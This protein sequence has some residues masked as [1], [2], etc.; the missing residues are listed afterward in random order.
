MTI[1]R[2][3]KRRIRREIGEFP[4]ALQRGVEERSGISKLTQH[5]DV[6][7]SFQTYLLSAFEGIFAPA[8]APYICRRIEDMRT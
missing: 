7:A 6:V 3:T 2:K 1:E 5:G 4:I 8:I